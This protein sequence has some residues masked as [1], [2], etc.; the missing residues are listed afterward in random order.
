MGTV[1]LKL[2]C[3]IIYLLKRQNKPCSYLQYVARHHMLP[4]VRP[5]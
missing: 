1:H 5:V 2:A 4:N 3:T